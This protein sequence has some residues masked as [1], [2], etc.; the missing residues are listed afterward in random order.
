MAFLLGQPATAV[1][2]QMCHSV[3]GV[4]S[5]RCSTYH[6]LSPPA[7]ADAQPTRAASTGQEARG[8]GVRIDTAMHTLDLLDPARDRRVDRMV[9]RTGAQGDDNSQ[10]PIEAAGARRHRR[11]V[12]GLVGNGSS[13]R[14]RAERARKRRMALYDWHHRIWNKSSTTA[15]WKESGWKGEISAR[16]WWC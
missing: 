1:Y 13:V 9:D 4:E 6:A 8:M 14:E 15:I 5:G 11:R 12:E 16:M 2:T 3:A 7:R 10:S